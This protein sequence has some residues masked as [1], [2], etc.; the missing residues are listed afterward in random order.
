MAVV[1]I[2]GLAFTAC[3]DSGGE[4]YDPIVYQGVKDGTTYKLT[5]TKNTGK[6]AFTP[7]TGDFYTLVITYADGT[8]KTSTGTVKSYSSTAISFENATGFSFTITLSNG[9]IGKIEGTI[10]IDG[11]GTVT[12]PGTLQGGETPPPVEPPPVE[13]PPVEPPPPGVVDVVLA[14]TTWKG[15]ITQ[16]R[17]GNVFKGMAEVT[18]TATTFSFLANMEV[19]DEIFDNGTYTVI[20]T[21]V[22]GQLD[23]NGSVFSFEVI[24]GNSGYVLVIV[25]IGR[26]EGWFYKQ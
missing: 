9:V 11:G 2:T 13:P 23:S 10:P 22:T 4:T 3:G 25:A 5:I 15:E 26:I 14:G 16:T 21:F 12:P 17:D 24:N 8:T 18:F 7:V 20:G 1:L 19:G 6:A